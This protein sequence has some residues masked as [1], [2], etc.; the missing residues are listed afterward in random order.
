MKTNDAVKASRREFLRAAGTAAAGIA[1]GVLPH[2]VRDANSQGASLKIG[3]IG[4]GRIGSALGAIWLKAGH[5]IM[6]SSLDL[7]HDKALAARLGGKARAGTSREAAAF[8]EVLLMA[9]PYGALP[10]L[11]RDLAD[12]IKGK[13]VIDAC[14]PFPAR[15]GEIATWARDKGAGLASAE[16]LPGARIVRAFNAIGYA[17]L[18]VL[19]EQKG[20]RTGMPIAGDDAGAIAVASRLVREAGLEP[21]L[22]GSL[23][24]GKYLIPGTPLAGEQTP[25]KIRQVVATLK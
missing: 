3:V 9:V 4:S 6:F 16:L 19:A 14:N 2:A 12:S 10:Q 25:E 22:V 8:G 5:E 13:V 18:P 17:R 1:L 24:M 20:E 11:G 23:A 21:V 7:E 15:D